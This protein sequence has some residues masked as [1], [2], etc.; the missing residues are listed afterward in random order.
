MAGLLA[1]LAAATLAH[2]LMSAVRR[3]QR[4]LAVLKTLGFERAQM[5]TLVLVQSLT[6]AG[7]AILIGLP[8]GVAAGR[9]AWNVYAERQGIAPEVVVP[10]PALLLTLPGAALVALLLAL[11]PARRAGETRPAAVLRAE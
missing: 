2:V 3:R 6:Y 7:A 1:G 10:V 5:R 11:L 8:L 9:F 4:D